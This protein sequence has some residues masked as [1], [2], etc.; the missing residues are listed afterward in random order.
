MP[1]IAQVKSNIDALDLAKVGMETVVAMKDEMVQLNREQLMEGRVKD[2]GKFQERYKSP[3]YADWKH[4]RNPIPGRFVPDL[5]D[6]GAFQEAM[7][8][9]VID[10]QN[11]EIYSTDSKAK[12]LMSR[13]AG[14]VPFFG[15]N[16]DSR[17]ELIA[18]GFEDELMSKVRAVTKL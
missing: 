8:L 5:Y 13:F 10:K 6:T 16:A 14:V 12:M 9:R 1:T 11:F 17:T 15:L 4:R 7:K 2:G 3:S 18:K